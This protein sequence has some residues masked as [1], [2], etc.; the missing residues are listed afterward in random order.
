MQ[1]IWQNFAQNRREKYSMPY[2]QCLLIL[3]IR[4]NTSSE[5]VVWGYSNFIWIFAPKVTRSFLILTHWYLNGKTQDY[6]IVFGYGLLLLSMG[7][8]LCIESYPIHTCPRQDIKTQ[9][10]SI[11]YTVKDKRDLHAISLVKSHTI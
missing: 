7:H 11:N 6:R 5:V 10:R 9:C 3:V 2:V 4:S 8:R 1:R